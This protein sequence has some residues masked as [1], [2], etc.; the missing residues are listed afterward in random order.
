MNIL[1]FIESNVP[2]QIKLNWSIKILFCLVMC[3]ACKTDT[4]IP[5]NLETLNIRL[6]KDPN[7]LNPVFNPSASSREV[8]QYIFVPLADYHPET[9]ELFPILIEKI[10][11]AQVLT[12]DPY[13]GDLAFDITIKDDAVW[14]DG[15]PIT[16]A[17][18]AFTVKAVK[19]PTT[20]A[21]AWRS[22][23][24]YIKNV[25]PDKE[26]PK[27]LRVI[28]DK[29]HML[30]KEI[31]LTSYIL[32]KHI[33]D[34]NSS[35]NKFPND[36]SFE[37]DFV[38]EGD[39]KSFSDTFNSAA[40]LREIL[41]G[42]GP[43]T[44]E[45]WTT[46]QSI[47]LQKKSD[48]WG[49]NYPENPFL[50]AG[51]IKMVFK[52]IPDENTALTAFKGNQIDVLPTS[53]A[54][55][56]EELQN[57]ENY[58]DQAHFLSPSLMRYYYIALNNA[59]EKLNDKRVR[60]AI[61]HLFDMETIIKTIEYGYGD[62]TIGHFNPSKSYYNRKLQPIPF[63]IYK[64][65]MLLNEA[66]WTDTDGDGVVDKNLNGKKVQMDLEILITGS[67]LSE[68]ISLLVQDAAKKAGINLT[69][70]RKKMSL[71]NSENIGPK[72]YNLVA[73]VI[74]QDAAP[75]DPYSRW[76]SDNIKEGRNY[77]SYSNP[78]ADKLMEDIRSEKDESKRDQLYLQL[79]EIMYEDQPVIWLYC[80]RQ[81]IIVDADLDA[82]QT[83]KRPG[84]LANTF[85][86]KVAAVN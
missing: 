76:H 16:A 68:N 24:K 38:A 84:Y 56:F 25:I 35:L 63:D 65:N 41:I 78:E 40:T 85:T 58:K 77:Y 20:N 67:Q 17:D 53:N 22:L 33:Y 7:K 52:I 27:K 10:P 54:G 50:Q 13:E 70:T 60:R 71:I 29:D 28:M 6:K 49:N 2:M 4:P 48:Y 81:K 46:N 80:P 59:D 18:Y 26:N 15:L 57:D 12:D 39:I 69:I 3:T 36:V 79:Q 75:D 30:A 31:A 47:V 72:K 1:N 21:R 9:L 42:A 37:N 23:F 61:A 64:A 51:S 45:S 82:K 43:Y 55:L 73:L 83:S 86:P 62:R 32:P 44:L 34:K 11:D 5:E 8:Y 19:L 66:G 74:S 14:S